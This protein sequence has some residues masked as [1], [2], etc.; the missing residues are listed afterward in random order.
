M[1]SEES[2]QLTELRQTESGQ[3]ETGQKIETESGQQ[4]ESEQQTD[5]GQDFPENPDTNETRTGHGQ[6]CPSTSDWYA[7]NGLHLRIENL[8]L[9]CHISCFEAI[10]QIIGFFTS[11]LILILKEDC[12]F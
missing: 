7:A 11:S 9:R 12:K 10:L 5:T 4:T 8:T 1:E 2:G 6:C 3:T